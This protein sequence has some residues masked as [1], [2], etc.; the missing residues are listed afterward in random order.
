MIIFLYGPDDYRRLAKKREI[1]AEF[2]KK[3]TRI[4]LGMF[5]FEEADAPDAFAEFTGSQSIFDDAAKMAVVENAFA[6]EPKRL[7][8]LLAP[9]R[10][11]KKITVLISEKEKPVKALAFLEAKPVISQK[12]EAL[13]GVPR[14]AFIAREAKAAGVVLAPSA[15]AFLGEV[16]GGNSWAL[17]TELRKLAALAFSREP[18]RAKIERKDLDALGLEAAPNYWGLLNGLRARDARARL[19]ALETLFAMNDPAAKLFNILAA[20]AEEKTPRMAEYDLLVKSGKLD[21][22]EVLLDLAIS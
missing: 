9:F 8:N 11:E 2:V 5:D 12:F 3:H 20:Q 18:A 22:E 15:A 14:A 4:G 13:T 7:A 17:V 21:Y 19:S 1:V 10:E 6:L 16:Y